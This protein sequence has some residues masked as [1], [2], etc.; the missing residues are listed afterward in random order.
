E[1]RFFRF[2]MY[3]LGAVFIGIGVRG[4]LADPRNTPVAGW[5]KWFLGGVLIHDLLFVP[6][7]LVVAVVV[8]RLPLPY[9]R[10]VQAA[11]LVGAALTLVALPAV[12]GYGRLPDNPSALPLSYGRNLIALLTAI[13]IITAVMAAVSGRR[14]IQAFVLGSV[15]R[16]VQGAVRTVGKP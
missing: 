4:I 3:G 10:Y 11:L 15:W 5:G 1:M 16:P 14:S 9:L 2:F 8:V 7:V 13:A 6:V 12:L